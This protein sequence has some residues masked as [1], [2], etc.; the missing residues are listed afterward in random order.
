M[1]CTSFLFDKRL[2]DVFQL[3]ACRTVEELYARCT[4][5]DARAQEDSGH[6]SSDLCPILSP[7]GSRLRR[8]LFPFLLPYRSYLSRSGSGHLIREMTVLSVETIPE[9]LGSTLGIL[10]SSH[11]K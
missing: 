2:N 11:K 7:P 4:G 1:Q 9:Q 8:A 3:N 5:R 10:L 6:T